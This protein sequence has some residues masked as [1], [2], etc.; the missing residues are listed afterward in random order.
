[1]RLKDISLINV[2]TFIWVI[3][4]LFLMCGLLAGEVARFRRPP[5]PEI[6]LTTP[7]H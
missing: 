7:S 1:M 3:I 4:V 6:I 2:I 5:I